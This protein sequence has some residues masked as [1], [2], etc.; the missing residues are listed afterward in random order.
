MYSLSFVFSF[1]LFLILVWSCYLFIEIVNVIT[2]FCWKRGT[3]KTLNGRLRDN[4]KLDI[5]KV[6]S[7]DVTGIELTW[8]CI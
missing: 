6:H 3:W 5:R 1:F 4:S 7:D 8:A 2:R